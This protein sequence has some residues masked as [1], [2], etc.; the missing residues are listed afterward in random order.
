MRGKVALRSN[1][2]KLAFGHLHILCYTIIR[3]SYV[4]GFLL[5]RQPYALFKMCLVS[6]MMDR[7]SFLYYVVCQFYLYFSI[8]RVL[9]VKS[10]NRLMS[11]TQAQRSFDG[12][13]VLLQWS[14]VWLRSSCLP[15]TWK[16]LC[17]PRSMRNSSN[18]HFPK[19]SSSSFGAW[20]R[21]EE[22]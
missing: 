8:H 4:K 13:W 22:T 2:P 5:A 3:V 20:S 17:S 15:L 1:L 18:W 6:Q 16:C 14:I 7:K 21:F 19:S 11:K 12:W 10:R 9:K